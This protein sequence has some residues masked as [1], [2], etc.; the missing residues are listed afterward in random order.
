MKPKILMGSSKSFGK[1]CKNKWYMLSFQKTK[2]H[3]ML[4]MILNPCYKG[5]GLNIQFVGKERTLQIAAEYDHQVLLPFL[6]F[7]YNFL[8][9]SDAGIGSFSFI[10]CSIEPRSLYDLMETIKEMA[11]SDERIIKPF[12]TRH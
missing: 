2:A 10:S 12:K 8:N 9:P 5:L 11:S 3:S 1:T 7:A 6:I 4:C